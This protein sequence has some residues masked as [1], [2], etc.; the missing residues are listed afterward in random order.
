METT[1]KEMLDQKSKL[2]YENGKLQSQVAQITSDLA[3]AQAASTDVTQL[4][5][6]NEALQEKL[7]QVRET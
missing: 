3:T 7:A 5:K 2:A 6:V 4:R 1:L